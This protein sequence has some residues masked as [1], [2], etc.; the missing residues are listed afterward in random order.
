M[1]GKT[2]LIYF[3]ER[4]SNYLMEEPWSTLLTVDGITIKQTLS[5]TSH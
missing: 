3:N 1:C 5:E 4:Q 2:V